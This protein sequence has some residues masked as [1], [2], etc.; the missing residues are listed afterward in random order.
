MDPNPTPNAQRCQLMIRCFHVPII[1]RLTLLRD[2]LLFRL[3]GSGQSAVGRYESGS[4]AHRPPTPLNPSI[5]ASGEE[6]KG[7]TLKQ[8]D[9]ASSY[10]ILLSYGQGLLHQVRMCRGSS[11]PIQVI[12]LPL[13]P[14]MAVRV[15]INFIPV[16]AVITVA[17][18]TVMSSVLGGTCLH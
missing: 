7:M 17:R 14:D 13:S 3:P 18:S 8:T 9:V 12:F 16:R 5:S 1:H 10:S 15:L 11:N 4:H 2:Q 6:G